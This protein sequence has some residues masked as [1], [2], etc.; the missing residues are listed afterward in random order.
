MYQ[1]FE[2][3]RV[4]NPSRITGKRVYFC[5]KAKRLNR[6]T[7]AKATGGSINERQGVKA[8][9]SQGYDQKRIDLR[10]TKG[11]RYESA[12]DA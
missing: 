8:P 7:V 6:V 1:R 5:G 4:P 12:V 3:S 9:Q 10:M 2:W 11:K